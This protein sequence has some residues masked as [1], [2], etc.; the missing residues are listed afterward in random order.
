M[1][2][3]S[4]VLVPNALVTTV[5]VDDSLFVYDEGDRRFFVLNASAAAVYER[6]DGSRTLDAIAAALAEE[7]PD[8]PSVAEDVRDAVDGLVELGLVAIV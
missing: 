8:A 6:C 4:A 7:H 5:V 1:I 3:G 2:A